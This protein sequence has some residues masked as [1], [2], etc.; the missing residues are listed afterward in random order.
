M[1]AWIQQNNKVSVKTVDNCFAFLSSCRTEYYR[2]GQHLLQF[3]Q[4]SR[5]CIWFWRLVCPGS[6]L[7]STR[8]WAGT[9]G[10]KKEQSLRLGCKQSSLVGSQN[11]AGN[12]AAALVWYSKC[13]ESTIGSLSNDDDDDDAKKNEFI[14]YQRNLRFPRSV[15]FLNGS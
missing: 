3:F 9:F 6:K 15:R 4:I 11:R 8:T 10:C 14:L 12:T 2:F 5:H 1:V 13:V 7:N